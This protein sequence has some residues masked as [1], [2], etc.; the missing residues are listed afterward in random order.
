MS[1]STVTTPSVIGTQTSGVVKTSA[2]MGPGAVHNPPKVGSKTARQNSANS[3]LKGQSHSGGGASGGRSSGQSG[4]S[5][6]F[7]SG[8]SKN[9][10]QV[11][12]NS[13]LNSK[14]GGSVDKHHHSSRNS[15]PASAKAKSAHQLTNSPSGLDRKPRQK[16]SK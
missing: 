16:S 8:H 12:G 2:G 7:S 6:G 5:R 9:S 10:C 13:G 15:K 1:S 11:S 3:G 4:S 14:V